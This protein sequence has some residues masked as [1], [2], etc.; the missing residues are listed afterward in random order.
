MAREV[1]V[2]ELEAA[3]VAGAIVIDVRE[4]HEFTTGRVPGAR[5]VPMSTVPDRIGEFSDG[6]YLICHSGPRSTRVCE[7]LAAQGI[8]A[9]NVAGGTAAWIRSGRPIDVGVAAS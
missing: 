9:I 2:D 3:I 1:S 6:V 8:D 5:S 4:D 7:F